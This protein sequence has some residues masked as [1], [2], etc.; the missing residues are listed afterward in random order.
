MT[1]SSSIE[2]PRSAGS[3]VAIVVVVIE[4]VPLNWESLPRRTRR[5]AIERQLEYSKVYR[6][7]F[8]SYCFVGG[9]VVLRSIVHSFLIRNYS[10]FACSYST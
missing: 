4:F 7:L 6:S 1:S 9:D 2:R 3:S 8:Q 5:N 10:T